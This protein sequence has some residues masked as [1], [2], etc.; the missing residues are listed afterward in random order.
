MYSFQDII[1]DLH[2][3]I[4]ISWMESKGQKNLYIIA[5]YEYI[6]NAVKTSNLCYD[7]LSSVV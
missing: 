1:P 3:S 2:L 6:T 7:M 4:L 5:K